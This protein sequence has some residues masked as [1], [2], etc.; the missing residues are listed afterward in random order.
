MFAL[1]KKEI[2]AFFSTPVGYLIIA[3]FLLANS[4]LM[5]GFN[6]E[7]N[8]LDN[9]YAQMDSLFI[10]A[11]ILFLLFIP[12]VTMRLFSDEHKEGTIELILT[13]PLTE[14]Q[15][16]LAKY[17]AGLVLVVLSILP[18]LVYYFSVH[19][20][21]ETTGNLDSAGIFGSYIGLFFLASGFVAIGTFASAMSK[22]QIISFVIA[23]ILSAF[24]YL[25]W[26][27]IAS[28]ISNGKAEL[29]IQYIGINIHYSSLSKGVIDSRDILY[30]IS[31][32]TFFVLGTKT[33]LI[34]RKWQ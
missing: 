22:N 26:D 9:G 31:L 34:S 24:F 33:I 20:L 30:F 32:N 21:G 10:L 16:V 14:L 7:Y 13:K 4:L 18:T 27:I 5:W 6:S 2:N 23:I 15:V 12:A 28:G 25:G 3:V 11:P 8:V 29:A 17:F 1:L 19:T